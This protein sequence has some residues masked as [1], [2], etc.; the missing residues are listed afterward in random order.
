MAAGDEQPVDASAL[1]QSI[2]RA[3][4]EPGPDR[5]GTRVFVLG[6]DAESWDAPAVVVLEMPPGYVLFR[7][8]HICHRFEVVVKGSLEAAGR[9]LRAGDVMTAAPAELYGPH[10]AGP[11][12]CTT[13][14]VFGS[15]EGVFR[16]LCETPDGVREFDFRKGEFPDDYQPLT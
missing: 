7:H 14:E 16:V 11:D 5:N 1:G 9:T 4:E 8:A 3:L 13:A 10:T 12:G 15:L 2:S 6:D